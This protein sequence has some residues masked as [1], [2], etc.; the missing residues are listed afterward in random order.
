M[1]IKCYP[2]INE[3]AQSKNANAPVNMVEGLSL[4]VATDEV[5]AISG[6]LS[7]IV[8]AGWVGEF[9][10]VHGKESKDGVCIN[11]EEEDMDD[12]IEQWD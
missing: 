2:R 5:E 10:G 11:A 8:G 12:E 9:E 4:S 3:K 6:C 7:L 1:N